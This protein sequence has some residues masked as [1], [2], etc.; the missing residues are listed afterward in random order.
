MA[1]ETHYIL[2]THI[3][4]LYVGDFPSKVARQQCAKLDVLDSLE[5]V[6]LVLF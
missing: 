3:I 6:N 4:L 5:V 1:L 2:Y